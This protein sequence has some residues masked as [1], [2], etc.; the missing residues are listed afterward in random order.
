MNH[1]ENELRFHY[2]SIGDIGFISANDIC[3]IYKQLLDDKSKMIFADRLLFS[4]TNDWKYIKDMLLKTGIWNNIDKFLVQKADMPIYIYGAGISGR[5]LPIIFPEYNWIGYIDRNKKGETCNGLPVYGI[6][7]CSELQGNALFI[8]SNIVGGKRIKENLIGLGI[9]HE[10]I[11][12][13]E[14]YTEKI[15]ENIYFEDCIDKQQLEGKVFVDAGAY[16]GKDTIHFFNWINDINANAV[17]FEADEKNFALVKNNLAKY[18]QV[19]F[20]NQGLSDEIGQQ[21]FLS[22]RGEMSNF[23]KEGDKIIQMNFLDNA[24]ADMQIG[25]IKMDIEGFEKQGILG[26]KEIISKQHPVLGISIYHKREDIW[27]IPKL[28]LDINPEYRF[29]LRHYSLGVVDTVLYAV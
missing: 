10:S 25:Y 29:F 19:R 21:R 22:G 27:E 20:Y 17:I 7:K 9:P 6:E 28:I 18:P 11:I 24:V 4:M 14:D 1:K 13:Y 2:K 16:D 3:C 23:S 15:A 8:V 12:T 26:A 5:R